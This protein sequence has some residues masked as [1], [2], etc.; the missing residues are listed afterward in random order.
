MA[1]YWKNSFESQQS[2]LLPKMLGLAFLIVKTK[3]HCTWY[4]PCSVTSINKCGTI[5]RRT[6]QRKERIKVSKNIKKAKKLPSLLKDKMIPCHI[7]IVTLWTRSTGW[8]KTLSTT[9]PERSKKKAWYRHLCC[10]APYQP[11]IVGSSR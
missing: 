9:A 8:C 3:I 7:H 2:V 4:C 1:N 10:W 5:I 11:I 6:N